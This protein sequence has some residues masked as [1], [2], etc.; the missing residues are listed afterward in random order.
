MEEL[1]NPLDA[2]GVIPS[3]GLLGPQ[4]PGIDTSLL[5]TIAVVMVLSL[6]PPAIEL[7][8]ARRQ[9]HRKVLDQTA[10]VS[11]QHDLSAGA[12]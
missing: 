2:T 6:L 12:R 7:E 1:L 10:G 4:I 5:P 3:T 11:I 9:A 8:G